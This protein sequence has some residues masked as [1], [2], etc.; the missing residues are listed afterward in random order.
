[1][2]KLFYAF[3]LVALLFLP[4]YS[5]D[6]LTSIKKTLSNIRYDNYWKRLSAI[7]KLKKMDNKE[8]AVVL[9]S[10]FDDNEA[11]IRESAVMALGSF[12]N[13][14]AIGY[15]VS[16]PLMNHTSKPQQFYTAWALGMIKSTDTLEPLM[17]AMTNEQSEEIVVRII[18]SIS[19]LP[20]GSQAEDALIAKLTAS[21]PIQI[22]AINALGRVGSLKAYPHILNR[23]SDSD[24]HIKTAALEALAGIKPKDCIAY[25]ESALKTASPEVKIVVLETLAKIKADKSLI[26]KHA[27]DMLTDKNEAVR[28]TAIQCL[29][30]IRVKDCIKAL[31]DRLSECSGR[32]R[33]DV[34]AALKDLTGQSF[35]FDGKTWRH[36]YD[37]NKDKIEI[38][39]PGKPLNLDYVKDATVAIPTFFEIPILGKNVIFIIDFSGSM[40]E[41]AD[42]GD[43]KDECKI[44]IAMNEL[45]A[46]LTTLPAE[47]KFN[48]I[49]LSTEATTINKRK[50][51]K[52]ILPANDSNKKM[53]ME[54][55]K[56]LW[57]KLEQIKRGRGDHYDALMEAMAEPEVDT[58][59]LLSDGK[60]TYGTY[61]YPENIIENITRHNRFRKVV[62]HTIMTGKKGTNRELMEKLASISNG[63]CVSK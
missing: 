60:P 63:V 15:L 58:I 5:V 44:D 35:G 48:V 16:I 31:V 52:Q 4:A 12:S 62:I 56:S 50:V 46:T 54:F 8:A 19:Q 30:E 18:A 41:E 1:M 57:D 38:A 22:A 14:D 26:L 33:Y 2:K 45:S 28:A 34:V 51:S 37:A 20:N 21:P 25:L 32:L 10:L 9:V 6:D 40:K 49:I 42:S 17:Q 7:S 59:F 29:R 36:W 13:K 53:A 39:A 55:V 3:I 47:T 61:M 43:N 27:C 11:P 24:V 23:V